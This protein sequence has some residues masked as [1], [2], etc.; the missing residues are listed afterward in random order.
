VQVKATRPLL[1]WFKRKPT[2]AAMAEPLDPLRT[3]MNSK[4]SAKPLLNGQE[5]HVHRA[6]EPLVADMLPGWRLMAQVSLGE[7]VRGDGLAA[8][9]S[10]N[11]K[12]V[13]FLVV[14]EQFRPRLAIE[15]QGSGHFQGDYEKRD[16]VKREALKRAGILLGEMPRNGTLQ[17]LKAMIERVPG[18]P[19]V[20]AADAA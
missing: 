5:I 14:D 10:V 2:L 20:P 6:L 16:A 9:N 17:D 13:D 7:I 12:R 15:Y 18:R 3:V 8:H 11:V 4:F 19:L 1:S